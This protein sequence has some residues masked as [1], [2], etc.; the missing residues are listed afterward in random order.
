MN[1]NLSKALERSVIL[2]NVSERSIKSNLLT[3]NIS[4]QLSNISISNSMKTE[5]NEAANE[6]EVMNNL[7]VKLRTIHSK[8]YSYHT[9][10]SV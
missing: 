3:R 6:M 7:L 10:I 8:I 9:G 2:S 1:P 5:Q 4:R